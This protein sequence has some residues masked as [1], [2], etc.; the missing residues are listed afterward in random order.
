MI[1]WM[2]F[3]WALLIWIISGIVLNVLKCIDII[4]KGDKK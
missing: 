4:K 2:L 3:L 1:Y